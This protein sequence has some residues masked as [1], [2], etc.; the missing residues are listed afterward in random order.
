MA[1]Q[2]NDEFKFAVREIAIK[3]PDLNNAYGK[4]N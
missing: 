4:E 2:D 1:K 3:A